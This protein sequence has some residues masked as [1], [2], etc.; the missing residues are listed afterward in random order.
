MR[1]G[2]PKT[3]LVLGN[4]E[5]SQ[6]LSFA[7]S[8]WLP[9]ALS[10]GAHIVVPSAD[11]GPSNAIA[12]RLKLTKQT[13]GK[14]GLWTCTTRWDTTMIPHKNRVPSQVVTRYTGIVKFS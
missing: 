11:S 14:S 3:E 5:R 13:V 7:R 6:L 4:E 2:R 12:Q 1:T 9:A 10:T 8:R